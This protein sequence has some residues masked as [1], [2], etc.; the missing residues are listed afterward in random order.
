MVVMLL[1]ACLRLPTRSGADEVAGVLLP[2][3]DLG[4]L[5]I[6]RVRR[7]FWARAAETLR[8]E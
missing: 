7:A 3:A 1:L 5:A 6:L 8:L 2:S 4:S